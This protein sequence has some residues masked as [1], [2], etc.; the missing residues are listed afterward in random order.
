[1][2]EIGT[3]T[4]LAKI[5]ECNLCLESKLDGIHTDWAKRRTLT[6]VLAR[7]CQGRFEEGDGGLEQDLDDGLQWVDTKLASTASEPIREK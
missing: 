1:M 2:G 4:D 6:I 5:V 3:Q 7:T